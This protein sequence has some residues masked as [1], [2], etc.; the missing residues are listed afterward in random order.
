MGVEQYGTRLTSKR[1]DQQKTIRVYQQYGISTNHETN[2][3]DGGQSAIA[4]HFI[5][6]H[7]DGGVG[8]IIISIIP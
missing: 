3:D 2:M 7:M 4:V 8:K 6:Q 1:L 5:K